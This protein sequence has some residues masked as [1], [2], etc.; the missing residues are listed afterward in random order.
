MGALDRLLEQFWTEEFVAE[1]LWLVVGVATLPLMM[2]A[3]ALGIE[4]LAG[5]VMIVGWFLV[6]PL[7]MFFGDQ[8]AAA[9][10]AEDVE[11]HDEND[12]LAILRERYARGELTEAEFERR[13]ERLLE[14]E[15]E[16]APGERDTLPNEAADSLDRD[17]SYER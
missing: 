17:V 10:F 9:L 11:E 16:S 15:S 1:E 6:T 3:G 7:L 12:P 4:A 5:I 8:V 2:L 13:V 14:T